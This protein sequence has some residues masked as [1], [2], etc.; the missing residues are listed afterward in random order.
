MVGS[1][2]KILVAVLTDYVEMKN[3]DF[4]NGD[5]DSIRLK[6]GIEWI[7]ASFQPKSCTQR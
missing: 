5:S 6:A 2:M 1:E 7:H 3:Y 4:F